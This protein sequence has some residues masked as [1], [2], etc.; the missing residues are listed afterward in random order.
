MKPKALYWAMAGLMLV[1]V[2]AMVGCGERVTNS[3]ESAGN[4]ASECSAYD[5]SM[6]APTDTVLKVPVRSP[7]AAD[8]AWWW[9]INQAIWNRAHQDIG[10]NVYVQCKPWASAVVKDATGFALPATSSTDFYLNSGHVIKI[11]DGNVIGGGT[12]ESGLGVGNIIQM[13]LATSKYNGPHTTIF[14]RYVIY[15][16]VAGMYWVDSNWFTEDFPD[17]V[18]V[19]FVSFDWFRR[20]VG[21]KY[22]VYQAM[23]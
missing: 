21:T 8:N 5:L 7:L 2:I 11:V 23:N 1:L 17:Y 18:F 4:V 9:Y 15:N 14:Y 10:Q 22:S 3:T 12:I 16:G 13:H 20:Y 19:H 6:I